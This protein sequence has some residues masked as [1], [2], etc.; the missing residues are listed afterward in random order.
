MNEYK[1][2]S[3]LIIGG[4]LIGLSI[5]YEFARKNFQV[6]VLSKNRSESAGFVAAGMLAPHA[7]GLENE[8]LHFGQ[9]SQNLMPEWIKRIQRDSGINCGLK[10]CGILVPFEKF[11]DLKQFPTFKNG[12]Y[13]NK[14]GI[15]K[16]IKGLHEKWEH[17]L[18]F[19]QDGQVDNRRRLM[20]ALERACTIHGVRF[21]EGAEIKEIILKEDVFSGVRILT[22][23]GDLK[24]IYCEKAVLCSGAWSNQI[25]NK[26]PV[27]PVKG[28]M[29]SIQ[30]P[31]HQLKRIIFGPHTYLVPRDDGLVIVGGTVEKE[32]GFKKGNTPN[33]I[34]QLQL[35]IN[36]IYPEANSW[37]QMEHWWG[38]RP[39][40]PDLKPII[41]KSSIENLFIAT[42]HYRNGV[43][44][45]AATSS[46]IYKLINDFS[47]N[48]LEKDFLDKFK[49]ERF[50]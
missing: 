18:L 10:Q 12:K 13:L 17:G 4:G 22:A 15:R 25:F 40:T 36:E 50:S 38:F 14:N 2:N 6:E 1:R 5:A 33:G 45:S 21:Q 34:K 47:L 42:G 24:A 29:L 7:E 26:V 48:E 28:Q 11:D 35:G 46:L 39:V 8:L 30:G 16:E 20:R 19:E 49:L 9:Y 41:G 43:L 27:Y 32:A 3:I 44:F 37:P 31:I 23:T